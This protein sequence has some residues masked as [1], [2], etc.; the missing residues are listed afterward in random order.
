MREVN[1]ILDSETDQWR[2]EESSS[3]DYVPD[4]DSEQSE[5]YESPTGRREMRNYSNLKEL[6][7]RRKDVLENYPFIYEGSSDSDY[8]PNSDDS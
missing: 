4:S 8:V 3:S 6:K 5:E 1:N 7:N 2:S